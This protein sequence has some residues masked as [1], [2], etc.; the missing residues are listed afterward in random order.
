MIR[1]LKFE[2]AEQ[3]V[4]LIKQVE[5][6]SQFM[7]MEPGE[8]MLTPTRYAECFVLFALPLI[9]NKYPTSFSFSGSATKIVEWPSL[10]IC[11]VR[12]RCCSRVGFASG[13][14]TS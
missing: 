7:L 12:F 5:A 2:D 3:F 4:D 1:E 14:F 6:E 13:Y 9:A 10:F 8:R 11:S